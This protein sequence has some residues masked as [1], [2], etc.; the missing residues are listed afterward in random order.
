MGRK[1]GHKA[2]ADETGTFCVVPG[3]GRFISSADPS[4]HR[5]GSGGRRRTLT[6]AETAALLPAP[7]TLDERM[8]RLEAALVDLAGAVDRLAAKEPD[9]VQIKTRAPELATLV[10]AINESIA[11]PLQNELDEIKQMISNVRFEARFD[12]SSRR[13]A[14][15]PQPLLPPE[16]IGGWRDQRPDRAGRTRA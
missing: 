12:V 3:C 9:I 1:L 7:P 11:E 16:R 13:Q 10:A 15:A 8:D 2:V 14:S 4:Q 5:R 6:P